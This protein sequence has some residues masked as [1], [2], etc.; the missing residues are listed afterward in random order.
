MK[1][2]LYSE[3]LERYEMAKVTGQLVR[4]EG[5]DKGKTIERAYSPTS[6]INQS[7]V[8]SIILGIVLGLFSAAA[9]TFV[10]MITDLRVRDEATIETIAGQRVLTKLPIVNDVT[11]HRID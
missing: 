10:A 9:L 7:L 6:P 5:P 2:T 4:Y 8:V 1:Q 3:M 11:V